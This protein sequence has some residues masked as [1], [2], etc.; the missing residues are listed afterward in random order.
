[1]EI[2]ICGHN[3]KNHLILYG[4]ESQLFFCNDCSKERN[5]GVNTFSN[6]HEYKPDNLRYLE[7]IA[8]QKGFEQYSI[9]KKSR[10]IKYYNR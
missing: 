6:F 5:M 3:E 4:D 1:M 2:C 9:A 7:E 10:A 8:Y